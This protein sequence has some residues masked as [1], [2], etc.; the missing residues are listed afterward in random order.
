MKHQ[1]SHVI[2]RAKDQKVRLA[3][4]NARKRWGR[5]RNS[6]LRHTVGSSCGAL[7]PK[8]TIVANQP[9]HP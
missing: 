6:P 8:Y 5:R 4:F 3:M 7:W 1:E 2:D 9:N